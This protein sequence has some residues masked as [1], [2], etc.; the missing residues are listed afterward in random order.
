MCFNP[1]ASLPLLF[2][3]LL[4]QTANCRQKKKKIK[5]K[6]RKN[7]LQG[8]QHPPNSEKKQCENSV[9]SLMSRFVV[10]RRAQKSEGIGFGVQIRKGFPGKKRVFLE[11]LLCV[12]QEVLCAASKR[13]DFGE[14]WWHTDV[15]VSFRGGQG[16]RGCISIFWANTRGILRAFWIN[17]TFGT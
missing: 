3:W 15:A 14:R 1:G 12:Q 16:C 4:W 2:S 9:G 6:M 5:Q 7:P 17:H 10:L 11:K 13:T 8:K